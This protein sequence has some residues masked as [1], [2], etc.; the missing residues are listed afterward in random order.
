MSSLLN[1]SIVQLIALLL[2]TELNGMCLLGSRAECN[3]TFPAVSLFPHMALTGQFQATGV[4]HLQ[5]TGVTHLCHLLPVSCFPAQMTGL[6][7]PGQIQVPERISTAVVW[8]FLKDCAGSRTAIPL[9]LWN[10]ARVFSS[11]VLWK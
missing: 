5:A 2:L 7:L 4:T 8:A 11:S 10:T 9:A 1:V 6:G 3:L